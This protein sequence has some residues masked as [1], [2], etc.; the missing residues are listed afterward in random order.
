MAKVSFLIKLYRIIS[1]YE[2]AVWLGFMGICYFITGVLIS[3]KTFDGS[4]I[5]SAP[6]KKIPIFPYKI[7]EKSFFYV[8]NIIAFLNMTYN[9]FC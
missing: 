3:S 4:S 1:T 5:L 8:K 7:K 6:A 2:L 9:N